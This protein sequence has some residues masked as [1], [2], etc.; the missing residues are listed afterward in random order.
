M[1]ENTAQGAPTTDVTDRYLPLE[2][3]KEDLRQALTGAFCVQHLV[4][5][6]V[7]NFYNDNCPNIEDGL[8]AAQT[9]LLHVVNLRFATLSDLIDDLAG[10]R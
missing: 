9:V 6:N 7:A 8:V 5:T 1:T 2:Q 4:K 3:A 10:V